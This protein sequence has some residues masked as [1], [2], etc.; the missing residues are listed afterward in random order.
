[1]CF[2]PHPLRLDALL[3]QSVRPLRHAE[4]DHASIHAAQKTHAAPEQPA[5]FRITDHNA[6]AHRE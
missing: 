5:Q 2:Q 3:T 6:F 1:M 4:A